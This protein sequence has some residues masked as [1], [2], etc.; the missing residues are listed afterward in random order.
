MVK[1]RFLYLRGTIIDYP[2]S[3]KPMFGGTLPDVYGRILG[4]FLT[5]DL[6]VKLYLYTQTGT[7]DRFQD[8]EVTVS[9]LG[10]YIPSHHV[11]VHD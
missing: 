9:L 11:P 2:A 7:V 1:P 6:A 5:L 4:G 10:R 8:T 3:S